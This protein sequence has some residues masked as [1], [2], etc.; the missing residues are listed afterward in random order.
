M[1]QDDRCA[2][3]GCTR[4]LT[5][6]GVIVA[7]RD[8][9]DEIKEPVTQN[10][11]RMAEGVID[12][13]DAEP[14]VSEAPPVSLEVVSAAKALAL[15]IWGSGS[16]PRSHLLAGINRAMAD[17][18]VSYAVSMRWIVIDD[19]DRIARGQ[20]S[21]VPMTDLPSERQSRGWTSKPIPP[22]RLAR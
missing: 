18:Y 8:V 20:V 21:P 15:T 2:S 13:V 16:R 11:L 14:D 12:E 1:T 6:R 7:V 5:G 10:A 22:Y 9:I 17:E 3:R 19:E 4:I